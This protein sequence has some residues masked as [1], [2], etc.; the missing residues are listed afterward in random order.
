MLIKSADDKKKRL[1]LLKELVE[2]DRLDET[3]KGWLRDELRKLNRGIDGER[4]AAHYLDMSFSGGK[5]HAVLHDLRLEADGQTA[6]I[7]H[8][9]VDRLLTFF[10]LETK[11]Y[12]CSLHINE[13]GEFTAEYPERRFGFESPLEQSRRHETVLKK[14]LE[15]LG[16]KG[17]VG[18]SPNFVHV[19]M[20][21]PKAIIQRPPSD[22]F[23]TSMVIKADQFA[24]W[25]TK[26][27]DQ[28]GSISALTEMVNVR[29][30]DT[31][32]EWGKKL[33]GEHRPTNPLE[34]PDFI[35]P[36]LRTRSTP[37]IRRVVVTEASQEAAVSTGKTEVPPKRFSTVPVQDCSVPIC[38][39]PACGRRL[40]PK[41]VTFCQGK[42]AWFGG[43]L[44]CTDHQA[45]AKHANGH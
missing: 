14:V 1:R 18:T 8:L 12:N 41:A 33:K 11:N 6:Q 43:R 39:D 30:R 28:M 19:V 37:A 17:R 21:H 9:V 31:V 45:A 25:H 10:L 16:I 44:Y 13:Q 4:D 24:T 40:T 29:G 3:Q 20:M 27:V 35:K 42:A 7:D 38:A 36:K 32:I 22:K 15:R 26:Y 23:D 2:S 5:N 34:L